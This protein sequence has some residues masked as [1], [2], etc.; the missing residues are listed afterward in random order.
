MHIIRSSEGQSKGCA[1]IK[2]IERDSAMVA[3][4]C[5]HDTIPEVHNI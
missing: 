5:M 4:S 1:F 3:I 2:F